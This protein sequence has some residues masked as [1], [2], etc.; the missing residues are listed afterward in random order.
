MY[1]G[2]CNHIAFPWC[3]KWSDITNGGEKKY[4]AQ[5][6]YMCYQMKYWVCEL[7][8]SYSIHFKSVLWKRSNWRKSGMCGRGVLVQRSRHDLPPSWIFRRIAITLCKTRNN[9]HDRN[10]MF[11]IRRIHFSMQYLQLALSV[12]QSMG[13]EENWNSEGSLLQQKRRKW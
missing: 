6:V 10:Q 4:W 11:R 13:R 1:I 7:F 2:M 12:C 9:F 5:I 3:L 8:F